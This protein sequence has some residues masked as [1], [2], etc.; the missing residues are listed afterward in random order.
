MGADADRLR[1]SQLGSSGFFR[2]TCSDVY[3]AYEIS[4]LPP[5]EPNGSAER[6]LRLESYRA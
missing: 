4:S 6:S 2:T 1:Y 3:G 5:M